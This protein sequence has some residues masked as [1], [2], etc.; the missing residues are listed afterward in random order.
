ME[1]WLTFAD[2][3]AQHPDASLTEAQFE[4][5]ARDAALF[6][7]NATRWCASLAQTDGEKALLSTC[8]AQLVELAAGVETGWDGVTS[9]NNHGYT[10]SYASGMDVQ[11][12]LG[13]QQLTIVRQTSQRPGHPLDAL[14][15]QRRQPT[16]PPQVGGCD[17][18]SPLHAGRSIPA[19]T[20]GAQGYRHQQLHRRSLASELSSVGQ[21]TPPP[22]LALR[23]RRDA[24][25]LT[26]ICI[27]AGWS[28]AAPAEAPEQAGGRRRASFSPPEAFRAADEAVRAA[29]WTLALEEKVLLPSGRTG[30]VTS[31]QDNRSGRCPHWY[32]EVE[33]M[34]DPISLHVQLG[35][36]FGQR[37]A[38][39]AFARLQEGGRTPSGYGW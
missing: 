20:H 2:Y 19:D 36:D 24:S 23:I 33:L 27:S 25:A 11:R 39:H 26:G 32:V 30:T 18:R 15:G 3:Q 10:E 9:V 12:Y 1:S 29:G 21:C 28:K 14:C 8:Q 17:M 38:T 34:S 4:L 13:Q 35:P 7:E 5:L 22:P 16:A 6:I 31:I 37:V